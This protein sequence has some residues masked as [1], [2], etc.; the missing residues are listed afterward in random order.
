[1]LFWSLAKKYILTLH[2]LSHIYSSAYKNLVSFLCI[3]LKYKIF[4][5][6]YIQHKG[7]YTVG[8]I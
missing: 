3:I 4:I 2:N 5:K 8:R 1:M 7:F 6:K